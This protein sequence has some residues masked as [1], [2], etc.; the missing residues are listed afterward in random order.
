MTT[1]EKPSTAVEPAHGEVVTV[2]GHRLVHLHA[3]G[4]PTGVTVSLITLDNGRD[5]QRPN[6]F[7]PQ[8]LTS[9]DAAITTALAAK[10]DA[11]A[12]TGKPGSFA[13][14][15]DM[16]QLV[17][18]DRAAAEEFAALGRRV[19]GR[20]RDAPVP[21]FALINASAM[22]GG[23][24][25]AL[26]CDYRVLASDTKALS[27]PEVSLGIVPGWGLSVAL[28]EAVG[29]RRAKEMSGTGN[30]ID[31]PTALAWG[32]VNHVVPHDELLAFTRALAVDMTSVDQTA[33]HN[34]F[35]TYRANA[36]V[37][38]DA[39]AEIEWTRYREWQTAS[40]DAGKVIAERRAA[41]VE[42]GRR[43]QR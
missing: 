35:S 10:P 7:G 28:P 23:L 21:T 36:A 43:Q 29:L 6:T 34:L 14:G 19:F 24:E 13:A 20:L 11:I 41:V 2:A 9:L 26:H 39:R 4:H 17:G 16:G 38:D 27:L 42:R 8:G 31:A 37:V 5:Q 30:F 1:I 25:L 15:A 18:F 32:L 40:P 12:I 33:L 22:G 3:P